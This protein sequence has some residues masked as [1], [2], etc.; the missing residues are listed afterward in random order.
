MGNILSGQILKQSGL[1]DDKDDDG[2][3]GDADDNYHFKQ[4]DDY[5]DDA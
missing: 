2:D 4:S 1:D 3:Y 5:D